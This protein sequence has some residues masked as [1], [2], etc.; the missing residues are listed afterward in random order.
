VTAAL[1]S[2]AFAVLVAAALGWQAPAV[3]APKTDVVRFKNGDR[4][5]GEVR[6]LARGRLEFN[7]DATG[8][9]QIEWDDVA[10]IESNQ[11]L[12]VETV[13]GERPLGQ[14]VL[15]SDGTLQ[16]ANDTVG[17][18][19]LFQLPDVVRIS[20]IEQGVLLDRLDG[21]VTAGYDYT[22]ANELQQFN[23]TG[24]LDTRSATRMWS[25]EGSSTMT[26]QEGTDDSNRFDVTAAYRHFLPQR[27]FVQGFGG[28]AGNDELGL[29][30]RSTVG[31]AYGSYVQ[32]T[33][34]REWAVYGG[35]AFTEE[36]FTGEEQQSSLEGV[37]GTQ[38]SFF[39][40]DSPEA[41]LDLTLNV[42]PSLTDFG[43]VRSEGRLRS[44]YEI[45]SDLF[46]E[47]SLYG[48]FD[49]DPGESAESNSDY[50]LVTSLGYSF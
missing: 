20:P 42:L 25:L 19:R 13:R 12:Q 31:A 24:G 43:R 37:L 22:K 3:A 23:F 46:F 15:S 33:N 21:Y 48:S 10:G 2:G 1:R 34:Q 38:Y 40:Y 50:G 45:V 30:L 17:T 47:V 32:Q 5:T 44:R 49:S 11:L 16:L 29:D 7:T 41:A 8:T 4:L 14:V 36:N 27:R 35:L 39:R 6:G 9:I 28:F 18:P 26:S